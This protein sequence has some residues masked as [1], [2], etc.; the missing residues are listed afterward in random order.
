MGQ[1]PELIQRRPGVG[2]E[3]VQQGPPA[4]GILLRQLLDQVGLDR[5]RDQILLSAVVKVAL[6]PAA[7]GV[8]RCDDAGARRLEILGLPAELFHR[9]VKRC[10]EALLLQGGP[11]SRQARR[12]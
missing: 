1:A 11:A 2:D 5:D 7:L 6:D 4:P 8:G 10:I 9:F 12:V 3:L